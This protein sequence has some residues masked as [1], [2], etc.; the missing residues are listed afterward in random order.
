[1]VGAVVDFRSAEA[2]AFPSAS[3]GISPQERLTAIHTQ[4]TITIGVTTMATTDTVVTTRSRT[5]GTTLL[6]TASITE[7]PQLSEVEHTH[8]HPVMHLVIGMVGRERW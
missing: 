2:S 3:V 1:M 4:A 8:R 5:T 6:P 7:R